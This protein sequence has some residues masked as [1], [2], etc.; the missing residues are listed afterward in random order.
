MCYATPRKSRRRVKIILLEGK[1]DDNHALKGYVAPL[2]LMAVDFYA[3]MLGCR[4]IEVQHPEP[5]VI[6]YYRVLDFRFDN[7]G[8]L[9][10]SVGDS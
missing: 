6:D 9:V 1:P 7:V 10:I 2:A 4:E 3:N 5:S 8:C